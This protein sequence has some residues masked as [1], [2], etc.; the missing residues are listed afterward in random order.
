[1]QSFTQEFKHVDRAILDGETEGF[2]RIHVR[3][4]TPRILGATVVGTHA[5]ELMREL[6]L[7]ITNGIDLNRI[8]STLHCY[9]THAVA[10]R[11]AADA[12]QRTRLT[13]FVARLF[14]KFLSW[15][16]C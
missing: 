12:Y 8:A 9:P 11:Q 4:G 16:R 7:A 14:R 3:R 2:V 15:Q 6:S 1:M 5:G 10:I 13:P